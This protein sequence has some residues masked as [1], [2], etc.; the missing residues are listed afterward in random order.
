MTSVA[1]PARSRVGSGIAALAAWLG[2]DRPAW[3]WFAARCLAVFCVAL[4]A[5]MLW[6]YSFGILTNEYHASIV[7][8]AIGSSTFQ[9]DL[10]ASTLD[11][12]ASPLWVLVGWLARWAPLEP[13]FLAGFLL[14]RSLFAWSMGSLAASWTDDPARRRWAWCGGA[15]STLTTGWLVGLPVGGDA[16][17]GPY[18]SQT[19][20]SVGVLLLAFAS[21][22]QGRTIRSAA[23]LGLA[24][25]L[26][27][28]QSLLAAACLVVLWMLGT[29]RAGPRQT[30]RTLATATS[31]TALLALPAGWMTL[32][33]LTSS[34]GDLHWTGAQLAHWAR[35]W[36]AGHFFLDARLPRQAI[37]MASL[38]LVPALLAWRSPWPAI[39]RQA[40]A[41]AVPGILVLVQILVVS[42]APSRLLFQLHLFRS[43]VFA[44]C[45]AVG[46]AIAHL[47]QARWSQDRHTGL[48][49]AV[50]G[51]L[52]NGAHF[53]AAVAVLILLAVPRERGDRPRAIAW[54]LALA[55]AGG[56]AWS[57]LNG[58]R[59]AGLMLL[60]G[61]AYAM[62]PRGGGTPR[63]TWV[64]LGVCLLL[65]FRSMFRFAILTWY[66]HSPVVRLGE[67]TLHARQLVEFGNALPSESVLLVPPTANTRPFLRRGVWFSFY[68]G[69]SFLWRK[70]AEVEVARRMAVLGIRYSPDERVDLDSLRSQWYAGLCSSIPVA[71]GEGVTHVVLPDPSAAEAPWSLHTAD[72]AL[73]ALGCQVP[74]AR[75]EGSGGTQRP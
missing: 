65:V 13:I 19:Y 63:S 66:S 60:V 39:R 37:A 47:S 1:P 55:G 14:S 9:G 21:A 61:I 48:L 16:V 28:M 4:C 22:I 32:H 18:F 36:L 10:L 69:A 58:M 49:G 67:R 8:K 59:G 30:L 56:C 5:W 43:D 64:V 33:S 23:L 2:P 42:L 72:S 51:L 45:A 74:E 73:V 46:L 27:I 50:L 29:S 35:F 24:F 26:N 7:L 70:G 31:T 34:H 68:D 25:N 40:I 57:V 54:V 20:L 15:V 38:L 52:L 75:G 12:Y 44:Y 53:Q 71:A 3:R 17:L 11:G 6:G 62:S 41:L